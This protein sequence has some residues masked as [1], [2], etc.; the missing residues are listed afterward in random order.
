MS[1][2]SPPWS[3]LSAL[4]PRVDLC[5]VV[6]AL[7]EMPPRARAGVGALREAGLDA[8]AAFRVAT[9][10]P[11][12]SPRAAVR[13]VHAGEEGW[14]R[15]LVD[16]EFGPVALACEG[17]VSLL[18]RPCVAVVG[19]RAC[20]PY[21]QEQAR[22][23]AAAVVEAGGIV[24]SGLAAGI[25]T[26]AH[27]A[28]GGATIA[29][30]GQGIDTR[31]PQWQQRNRSALLAQGGLVVSELHPTAHAD[32][33]TFPVRNR[34]IAGLASVVV[35]VEAGERSGARNTASHAL[36]YGRDVLAVPG[37]L[38]A[39]ASAGCLDLIEQG[40]TVVRGPHTVVAAAGLSTARRAAVG[41]PPDDR[42][43]ALLREPRTPEEVAAG[44]ELPWPRVMEAL[45][46]L[47]LTGRVIRLP[48]R[49]YQLRS[50]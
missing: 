5:A 31:M 14:P 13:F 48:G 43:F 19:A 12:A 46:V 39:P 29:V 42:L 9:D 1:S 26:A 18:H 17:D 45:G 41:V 21:G 36:R 6:R 7:L 25:D 15:S 44:T 37:P 32:T 23:I 11:W 16:L 10:G 34:I 50:P 30:L 33:F 2:L 8:P 49:R 24:V 28:A 20:T 3:G 22:R 38:G 4:A 27:A 40:A 47:E 35:V